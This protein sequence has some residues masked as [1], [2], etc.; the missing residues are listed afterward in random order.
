MEWIRRLAASK[1]PTSF[2]TS[3]LLFFS[4]TLTAQL[5]RADSFTF[6]GVTSAGNTVDANATIQATTGSNVLSIAI[7]NNIANI[8]N[9][10]QGVSGLSFQV[11]DSTGAVVQI[12][13]VTII[14][15]FGR[16]I[17]FSSGNTTAADIGSNGSA[18]DALGW[19]LKTQDPAYLNALGFVG[20]G[21]QPPDELILGP[22]TGLNGLTYSSANGSIT[23]SS[24]HQ[25]FVDQTAT[26]QVSLGTNWQEGYQ[27]S[28]VSMYFGTGPDTFACQGSC[29]PPAVPEPSTVVLLGSG[30]GALALWRK[31]RAATKPQDAKVDA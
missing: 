19:G 28:N 10:G 21:T 3:L 5:A 22:G 16:E 2:L 6:Q 20:E 7:T 9:V 15:Q 25:P 1:Y 27:F 24:A 23:N 8:V 11:V 13:P 4:V 30:L 31:K 18:V 26:F 12:T 29:T 17:T 14:S